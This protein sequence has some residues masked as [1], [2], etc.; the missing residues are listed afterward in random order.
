MFNPVPKC[1]MAVTNIYVLQVMDGSES[2]T[3]ENGCIPHTVQEGNGSLYV[4]WIYSIFS[5]VCGYCV[6]LPVQT[7][8]N[9][10]HCFMLIY[11]HKHIPY[12]AYL[13]RNATVL[14]VITWE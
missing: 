14:Q 7:N 6:D 8:L 10:F 13:D 11:F 4:L 3:S 1:K 5:C 2:Q 12:L 9:D